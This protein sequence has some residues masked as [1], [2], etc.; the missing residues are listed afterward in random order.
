M[1]HRWN[2]YIEFIWRKNST[3]FVQRM[4]A[5]NSNEIYSQGGDYYT[6]CIT[7]VL[8]IFQQSFPAVRVSRKRWRD[9][10]RVT[11]ALKTSIRRKNNLYKASL[12]HHDNQ[13]N[14]TSKTYKNIL[15]KCL[16]EAEVKCYDEL[17]DNHKNSVYNIWKTLHPIINPKKG[18]SFTTINKL[19]I[20][21]GVVVD[22]QQIAKS[23]ND[24]CNIGSKLK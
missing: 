12:T 23:I 14:E 6:K 3:S 19:I 21:Q 11:K 13:K 17:F 18:Q 4:E 20:D 16:K 24:V 15:R 2:T 1:L 7:V 22:K 8:R 9:K 10:P 5:E